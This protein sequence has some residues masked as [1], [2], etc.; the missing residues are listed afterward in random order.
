MPAMWCKKLSNRQDQ[1]FV[2][3]YPNTFYQIKKSK[4][5]FIFSLIML[6][7]HQYGN[8]VIQSMYEKAGKDKKM[9]LK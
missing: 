7:K 8:Y 5:L 2:S 6:S 3:C 1:N 4:K 9:S